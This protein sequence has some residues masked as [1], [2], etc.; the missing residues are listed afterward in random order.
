MYCAFV[1]L[2]NKFTQCT[3]QTLRRREVVYRSLSM[4]VIVVVYLC[5]AVIRMAVM[6]NTSYTTSDQA[7]RGVIPLNPAH[8]I[9]SYGNVFN[10]RPHFQELSKGVKQGPRVCLC[11]CVCW[12]D[13]QCRCLYRLL[14]V[15]EG[16]GAILDDRTV[17]QTRDFRAF[18]RLP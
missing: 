15:R 10:L 4:D 11:V 7:V 6:I 2:N 9:V 17:T 12:T 14:C 13:W 3:L 18:P 1:G 8:S 5:T 16:N